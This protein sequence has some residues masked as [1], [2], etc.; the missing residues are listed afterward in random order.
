MRARLAANWMRAILLAAGLS[1]GSASLASA[2]VA[3][4][5]V[6]TP[7]ALGAQATFSL[8]DLYI[9]PPMGSTTLGGVPFSLGPLMSIRPGQTGTIPVNRAKDPLA[10]FLLLNSGNTVLSYSNQPVGRVRLSFSDGSF[11]DTTL[12]V[13][14]NLREW[15]IAA[16]GWAVTTLSSPSATNVWTGQALP[17]LGGGT[18]VIDMLQVTVTPSPHRLTGISVSNTTPSLVIVVS[19][20]TIRV[21]P[22]LATTAGGDDEDQDEDHDHQGTHDQP[23]TAAPAKTETAHD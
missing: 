1:L 6:D 3:G 22:P 21:D 17:A 14:S 12:I 10:A 9:A 16:A 2:Q 8:T 20:A 18:A 11:Q 23:A 15:R 13:G 5:I 7:L 19:G 4:V